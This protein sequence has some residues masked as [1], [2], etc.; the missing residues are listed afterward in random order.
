LTTVWQPRPSVELLQE[1]VVDL[2]GAERAAALA[3]DC[4]ELF[5]RHHGNL[6]QCLRSLYDGYARRGA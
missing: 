4:R 3:E 1:L 2:V 5:A 6:R